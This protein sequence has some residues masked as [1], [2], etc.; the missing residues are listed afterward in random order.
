MKIGNI[1]YTKCRECHHL[2]NLEETKE[3]PICKYAYR[4]IRILAKIP[5]KRIR[6]WQ[7]EIRENWNLLESREQKVLSMR[8]GLDNNKTHTLYV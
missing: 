3:C 2:F 4:G 7:K 8:Y 5:K 1:H 6:N